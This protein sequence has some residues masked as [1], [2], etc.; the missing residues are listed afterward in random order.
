MNQYRKFFED[1]TSHFDMSIREN[2]Y[3][4]D[5]TLRVA[6]LCREI[7]QSL[8]MS[9]YDIE[10]AELTGLFHDLGR[11]E[12]WTKYRTFNDDQSFDHAKLSV[13][14][15]QDHRA[16]D[17]WEEK[18]LVLAAVDNHN[19]FEIDPVI[20]D[21]R[22][23][24]FCEI[25]RDA[26]KLDILRSIA[27]GRVGLGKLAP[28]PEDYSKKAINYIKNHH[29]LK[30]IECPS[31]ADQALATL[32]LFFDI[33]FDYTKKCICDEELIQKI[34]QLYIKPHPNQ[35]DFF[36]NLEKCVLEMY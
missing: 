5:H 33:N 27:V 20:R 13:K 29:L 36:H 16:L 10:L 25:I 15:L 17:G 6:K 35:A 23:I 1:Y 19:K 32:A 30:R 26:D 28:H 2:K 3:K 8:N 7:A 9:S 14:I 22:T 34:T 24:R 21:E 31:E 11:F 12:Q 4:H 18:D